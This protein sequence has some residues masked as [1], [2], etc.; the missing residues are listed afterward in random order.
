MYL[1]IFENGSILKTSFL[2]SNE[3]ADCEE[4]YTVIGNVSAETI[5]KYIADQKGK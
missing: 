4:G 5:K 2:G 3:Y 1:I